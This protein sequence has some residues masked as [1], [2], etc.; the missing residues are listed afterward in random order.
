MGNTAENQDESIN[1]A[2]D[3]AKDEGGV[4]SFYNEEKT[5]S[6]GGG[7]LSSILEVGVTE[8]LVGKF[9]NFEHFYIAKETS[10]D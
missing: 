1:V 5:F 3:I 7:G 6:Y 4:L 2:A 8:R 10:N 9:D